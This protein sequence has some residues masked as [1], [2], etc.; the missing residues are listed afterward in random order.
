M[1][2]DGSRMLGQD[3]FTSASLFID[4][5][6][7]RV[8]K[9]QAPRREAGAGYKPQSLPEWLRQSESL[10]SARVV[11]ALP[12]SKLPDARQGAVRVSYAA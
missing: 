9:L 6:A 12:N 7:R 4:T 8:L 3:A 10:F 5:F 2:N 11:G 1:S